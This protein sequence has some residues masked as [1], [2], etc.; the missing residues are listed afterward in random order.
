MGGS[1][2]AGGWCGRYTPQAEVNSKMN[3]IPVKEGIVLGDKFFS[4]W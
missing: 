2:A 1:V 3:R 4:Y